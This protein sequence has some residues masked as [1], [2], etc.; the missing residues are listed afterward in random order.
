MPAWFVAVRNEEERGN[1][2]AIKGASGVMTAEAMGAA[3]I[4]EQGTAHSHVAL[5][6]ANIQTNITCQLV[7][8]SLYPCYMY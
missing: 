3:T 1:K 8:S 4:L 5:L 6:P 2:W 7:L